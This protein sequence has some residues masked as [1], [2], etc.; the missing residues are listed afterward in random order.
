MS[1]VIRIHKTEFDGNEVLPDI[2]QTELLALWE[3]PECTQRIRRIAALYQA[4]AARENYFQNYTPSAFG[5]PEYSRLCGIVEG[6]RQALELTEEHTE[7]EILF[8]RGNR[9]FLAVDK[10]HLRRSYYE[11]CKEIRET[12]DAL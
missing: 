11:E 6:F 12:F 7:D 4:V 3:D 9:I 5:N 10:I 8:K 1:K 2:T